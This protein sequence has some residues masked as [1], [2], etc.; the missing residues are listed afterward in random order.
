MKSF[1]FLLSFLTLCVSCGDDENSKSGKNYQIPR[2]AVYPL[3]DSGIPGGGS[4]ADNFFPQEPNSKLKYLVLAP[5]NLLF[6]SA[7]AQENS[8]EDVMRFDNDAPQTYGRAASIEP[9]DL[10]YKFYSMSMFYDCVTREQARQSGVGES[11][12]VDNENDGESVLILTAS[13]IGNNPE[14]LTEYVSWTDL[15][16]SE[17]VRGLL[18]NK[19]L[20]NDGIRTKTR[21]DLEIE[22]GARKVQSL[23]HVISGGQKIYIKAGFIEGAL[24]A[25]GNFQ[26]HEIWGRYYDSSNETIVMARAKSSIG[27]GLSVELKRCTISGTD[28]ETSCNAASPVEQH[29][30]SNGEKVENGTLQ[31]LGSNTGDSF[32]RGMTEADFFTP[33]FDI[34]NSTN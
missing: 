27:G 11:S 8:C 12:Q 34:N 33:R 17:N 20:Q 4:F 32:Y 2:F 21:V 23:L 30:D 18:V 13:N 26:E 7:Y 31:Q 19:Y 15:P 1:I 29:Y 10:I 5:V 6:P 24:D 22:N 25:D 9:R 28:I 14:N 16:E 3:S